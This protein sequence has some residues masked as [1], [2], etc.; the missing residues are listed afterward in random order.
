MK[1]FA[2]FGDKLDADAA[3]Q[4]KAA[5]GALFNVALFLVPTAALFAD[6]LFSKRPNTFDAYDSVW[7][8]YKK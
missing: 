5:F 8:S 2:F 6:A 7:A 4:N 1:P 3:T